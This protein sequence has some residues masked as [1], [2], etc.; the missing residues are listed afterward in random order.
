[1][2]VSDTGYMARGGVEGRGGKAF[3][4]F[5]TNSFPHISLRFSISFPVCSAVT[6]EFRPPS[7]RLVKVEIVDPSKF[8]ANT[9]L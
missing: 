4:G 5:L 6:P 9:L 3:V 2:S 8:N 1:M 7:S